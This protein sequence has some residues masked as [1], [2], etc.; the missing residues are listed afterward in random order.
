MIASD[1]IEACSMKRST[2]KQI[3]ATD[4][5]TNLDTN[6]NQLANFKSGPVQYF[7][8]YPNATITQCFSG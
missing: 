4:Y 8:I 3:A 7:R 1:S 5:K 6:P 2:T